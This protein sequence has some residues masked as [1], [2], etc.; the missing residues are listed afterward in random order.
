[1]TSPSNESIVEAGRLKHLLDGL[2]DIGH[3]AYF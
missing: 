2:Y 1:M 3:L